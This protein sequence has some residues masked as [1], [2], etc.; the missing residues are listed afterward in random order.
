MVP[1]RAIVKVSRATAA[2][3]LLTVQFDEYRA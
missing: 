2:L 1:A 3:L